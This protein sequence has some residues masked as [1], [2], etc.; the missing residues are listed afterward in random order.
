MSTLQA[1]LCSTYHPYKCLMTVKHMPQFLSK[2]Q[3]SPRIYSGL[4]INWCVDC[5]AYNVHIV[6]E[7]GEILWDAEAC[8]KRLQRCIATQIS[9][10]QASDIYV[11]SRDAQEKVCCMLDAL[12]SRLLTAEGVAVLGPLLQAIIFALAECI[13]SDF[14]TVSSE[15]QS[16][17]VAGLIEKLVTGVSDLKSLLPYRSWSVMWCFSVRS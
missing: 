11:F 17:A 5:T 8:W 1:S 10:I 2:R 16:N 9:V 3:H 4:Y 6:I 12:L 13:D 7:Q 14:K 15:S